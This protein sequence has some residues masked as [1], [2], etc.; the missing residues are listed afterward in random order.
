M[1]MT[2]T[3]TR[4]IP[5]GC[6]WNITGCHTPKATGVREGARGF[7]IVGTKKKE[8]FRSEIEKLYLSF[9]LFINVELKI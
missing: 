4:N 8:L 9:P 7:K 3:E 6:E 1:A 2:K 5:C